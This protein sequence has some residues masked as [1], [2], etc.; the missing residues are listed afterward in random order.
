MS[1]PLIIT[2]NAELDIRDARTWYEGKRTGLGERF[3]MAV[4]TALGQIVRVPRGG[5]EIEPGVRRVVIRKFP[6]GVFYR[7][8]PDQIAILAVYHSKRNP[9]TWKTRHPS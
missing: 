7:V 2:P 9:R 6:Y 5:S 3:V 1:L 4:E 8:D